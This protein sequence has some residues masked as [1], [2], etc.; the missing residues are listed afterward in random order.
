MNEQVTETLSTRPC[1]RCGKPPVFSA[2]RK[3]QKLSYF[4]PWIYLGCP[5]NPGRGVA[6]SGD[7]PLLVERWNDLVERIIREDTPCP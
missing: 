1:P 6:T 3:L 2:L 4:K 5:C 7:A